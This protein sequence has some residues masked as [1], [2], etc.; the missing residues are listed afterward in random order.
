[1]LRLL[2]LDGAPAA[3]PREW[4]PMWVEASIPTEA[5]SEA[6]LWRGTES[7][8]LSLRRWGGAVRV[9]AEWPRSGTGNYELRLHTGTDEQRLALTVHPEKIT[10]SAYARLLEDLE[11]R[12]PATVALALQRAGGLAGVRLLP[13]QQSTLAEELLRLQ[14]AVLGTPARP[15]LAETLVEIARDPHQILQSREL[16]VR[17]E[18][19]RRPHPARLVHAV[20]RASN[21]AI[22]L[23]PIQVL[24]TR[25]EH[26]CDV[27]ENRLV[28]AFLEQVDRRL[29]R[30]RQVL[31]PLQ[32]Q[33]LLQT[34]AGLADRIATARRQASFLNEVGVLSHAPDRIT[35]VLLNR[36][37][38]RAALETYLEFQRS[39]GVHLEEEAL[40]APLENLPY[41]YQLWGTLQVIHGLLEAGTELG[42]T[43]EHERLIGRSL[44]GVF[45]RIL[46]DGKAVVALWHPDTGTMVRLIPECSYGAGPGLH[47]IT[48]S[49]R[50]DIAVEVYPPSSPPRVWLFDPKY[51]L[52]GE[53][54]E[55]GDTSGKPKKIDIDK[56]HAYRDAI[57]DSEGRRVVQ[58]AAIL[59]PG[60]QQLY[61]DGIEALSAQPEQEEAL[62]KRLR[63]VFLAA[64]DEGRS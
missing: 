42:Y 25:V 5:W 37:A 23:G 53:W 60:P 57:R 35:M 24:D 48:Y 26:T 64:L 27:Y 63:Q 11:S 17:R 1:M 6:Q 45:V 3:A 50:P 36:P 8:P 52:D 33:A 62:V 41:L 31:S 49:Q 54:L 43:V 61:P 44:G 32:H 22:D 56:M 15:G 18:R 16:W 30:L 51:K 40:D 39:V 21:L 55:G 58:Y 34:A 46:P 13:P 4:V 20:A 28:K 59:Y 29:R 9:V 2:N 47:S 12:L 19:A 7:L 14:R 38:Y 10:S